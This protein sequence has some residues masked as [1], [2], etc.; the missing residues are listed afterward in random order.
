M[1]FRTYPR[2]PRTRNQRWRQLLGI[3]VILAAMVV[4][5]MALTGTTAADRDCTAAFPLLLLGLWM[6][7][8]EDPPIA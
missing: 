3:V 5:L 2:R 4:F 8:S 6:L 1:I 7:T